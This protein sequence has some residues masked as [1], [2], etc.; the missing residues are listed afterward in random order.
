[1]TRHVSTGR[2][3]GVGEIA[4]RLGVAR[5]SA[6]V[7]VETPG[8]PAAFDVL[9]AGKLWLVEDVETWERTRPA[10]RPV[11]AVASGVLAFLRAQSGPVRTRELHAAFPAVP[12]CTLATTLHRLG[13]RGQVARPRWGWVGAVDTG[14]RDPRPRVGCSTAGAPARSVTG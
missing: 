14:R 8:F 10:G 4:A 6:D 5:N 2:L 1:M 3:V 7:V 13:Q 12:A 9:G 11:G